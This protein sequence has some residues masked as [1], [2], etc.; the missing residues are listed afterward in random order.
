MWVLAWAKERE[1]KDSHLI[2][3]KKEHLLHIVL[4][5]SLLSSGHQA[6]HRSGCDCP[7]NHRAVTAAAT[8]PVLVLDDD[9]LQNRQ[10]STNTGGV[11]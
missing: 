1:K 4:R 7:P 9:D 2:A 3:C 8:L 10:I 5:R 6:D 11:L